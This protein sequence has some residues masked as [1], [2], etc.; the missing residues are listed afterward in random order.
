MPTK[1]Q[2]TDAFIRNGDNSIKPMYAHHFFWYNIR[3]DGGLRVTT[4]GYEYLTK[5]LNLEYFKIDTPNIDITNQY[6]IDLDRLIKCPYYME[7]GRWKKIILF[8]KKVYF[9]LTMYNNDFE[10][11]L[12]AH[13]L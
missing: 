1:Q 3:K 6:L 12:R 11:F 4:D 8:D 7:L 5:I 2:Y 10:K 13:K 9:A